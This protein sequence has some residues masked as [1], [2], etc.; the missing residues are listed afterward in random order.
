MRESERER[1]RERERNESIKYYKSYLALNQSY[2]IT[3]LF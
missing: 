3:P 2:L 1:E